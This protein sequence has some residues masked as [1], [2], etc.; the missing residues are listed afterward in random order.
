MHYCKKIDLMTF[1]FSCCIHVKK[2]TDVK[3]A[4]FHFFQWNEKDRH[5][6]QWMQIISISLSIDVLYIDAR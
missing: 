1:Q 2:K 3:F 4:C 6:C 5:D